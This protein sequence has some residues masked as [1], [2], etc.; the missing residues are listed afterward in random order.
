M[1]S[2]FASFKYPVYE[3]YLIYYHLQHT[4]KNSGDVKPTACDTGTKSLL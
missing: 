2:S 4:M 3:I 1:T